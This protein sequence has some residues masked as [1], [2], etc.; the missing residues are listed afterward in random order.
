MMF[1]DDVV[2]GRKECSYRTGW[3]RPDQKGPGISNWR[4]RM[5]AVRKQQRLPALMQ[6]I[7]PESLAASRLAV[8]PPVNCAGIGSYSLHLLLVSCF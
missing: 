5:P 7:Q 8:T 3:W 6:Q 1:V 2:V 4:R